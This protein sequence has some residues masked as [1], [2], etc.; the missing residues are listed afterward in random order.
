MKLYDDDVMN[1]ETI[2]HLRRESS[3]ANGIKICQIDIMTANF[4]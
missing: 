1:I 2:T 3:K 4:E